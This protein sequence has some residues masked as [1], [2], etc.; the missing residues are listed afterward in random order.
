MRNRLHVL[1]LLPLVS[2]IGCSFPYTPAPQSITGNWQIQAGSAITSPPTGLYLTGALQGSETAPTGTFS[3]V[4]T[5]G[6]SPT[7]ISYTST[8]DSST[9]SL[10]LIDSSTPN[11][12]A[13]LSLSADLNTLATGT[14]IYDPPSLCG[15]PCQIVQTTP[16]VGVEIAPLNGTYSGTL[17]GTLNTGN[18]F[19]TAITSTPISGTA[20]L[21]LTQSSTPNSSG[22]FPLTGTITFPS[23]SGMSPVTLPGLISG[24]PVW[25]SSAPCILPVDEYDDCN[26]ASSTLN[27]YT[28]PTATQI[29][30]TNLINFTTSANGG[31]T[32]VSLTG[33]LTLQ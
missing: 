26:I 6:G 25:L 9:G 16:V 24:T 19:D 12:Q 32:S 7:I 4:Y 28:N 2:L 22:Q 30:V 27:A 31:E 17:T 11:I 15:I 29:T 8:Y 33:I 21:V 5:S 18:M 14:I 10:S 13:K 20:T 1:S 3:T 23:S